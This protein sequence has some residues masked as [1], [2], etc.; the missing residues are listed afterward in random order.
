M[1]VRGQGAPGLLSAALM[2]S[3]FLS[4]GL[5]ALAA[6]ALA[7]AP[8][9]AATYMINVE[10]PM[11]L[12]SVVAGASGNT[13]FRINP[14]TGA[15]SVQS[16]TGRRISSAS[17]RTQVSI[18]CRPG[19]AGDTK[20]QTDNISIRIG[21]VG[22][23]TGR[24]RALTNFAVAMGTGTLV[25]SPS[26][27]NPLAFQLAPP[28]DNVMKTF[29]VGAD[30]PVAGDDS[31]LPSGVGENSFYVTII[32]LNGLTLS[33][34]TDSGRLQ[35]FRSLAIAKTADLTFG[36][37]QTPTSGSSTVSLDAA[38]GARTVTGTAFA[39]PTPTATR[40][41]FSITGEGGQQV[42]LSIPST[43]NLV[44]PSTLTVNLNDTAPPAP[45]LSGALGSAGLYS[46]TVGG[47]FTITNT[48]RT[49]AYTGVL[50]VSVDYN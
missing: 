4:G 35:A 29:F 20:C 43:L 8:A 46:F 22:T 5:G 44:G 11:D 39:Y 23:L 40:A 41:A 15:V 47:E 34:D 48:T 18:M 36:R 17:A 3:M 25:G 42:S 26:G 28:G 12:G 24:A 1:R 50:S 9:R 38:T 21:A 33:S 30:F 49:G 37:I 19:R 13:V 2:R 45:T 10:G 27:A 14:S 31:G 32:D 6:V 16:G 7:G